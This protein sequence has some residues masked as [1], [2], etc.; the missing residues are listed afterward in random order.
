MNI[1]EIQLAQLSIPLIRP[2]I[3][4]VR[5]TE[6]VNDVIV[7]L[8]TDGGAIGY[9]S[10]ASTPAITGD[11]TESIIQAINTILGPQLLGRSIVELNH[12][13]DM[14]HQAMPGNTSAKAAVDI[15][16]HDLFAQ[17]C[18]LP[19][20]QLL[21]GH[22]N[23]VE[24]C[25]TISVKNAEE[26]VSDALEFVQQGYKTLK[27]KLGLNPYEDQ[28]RISAIR[29]ALG[30][31]VSLLV[32]ANQGWSYEDSVHMIR[33]FEAQHLNIELVEQPVVAS[34]RTSLKKIKTAMTSGLIADEACFSPEDVL[35]LVHL[36]ACHGINIKLMKS[37]GLAK[38][39][40]IYHIAK[41]AQMQIMVGCMLESPIGIAAISSFA[42][43]KTDILYA[44]L[45]PLFLIRENYVLGG[46]QKLGNKVVLSEQPGLGIAGIAQGLNFIGTIA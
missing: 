28:Q 29:H 7:M 9:G 13:L 12:L 10:A 1:I 20:Y 24:S 41:T 37:A 30:N 14:T 34:D 3:T 16:L 5:R 40:A 26:M 2:F 25:I 46:A 11:S 21:G 42:A 4:A 35:N 33:F 6:C 22:K 32:D 23:T 45:D 19:L 43:S 27:I 39:Q 18:G 36:D 31:E 15:A 38:A 8:K 17:Y 44:D